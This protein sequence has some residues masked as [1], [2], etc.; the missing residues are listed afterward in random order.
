MRHKVQWSWRKASKY[1]REA[2]I[3]MLDDNPDELT[4]QLSHLGVSKDEWSS[5]STV[6]KHELLLRSELR[7][8]M[9]RIASSHAKARE[10]FHSDAVERPSASFNY[11][12]LP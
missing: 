2:W 9:H 11:G 3:K 10:Q 8:T 6:R 12:L 4:A 5:L 1:E 7:A